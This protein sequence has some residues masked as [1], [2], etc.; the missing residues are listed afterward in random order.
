MDTLDVIDLGAVQ[1]LVTQGI[2]KELDPSRLEGFIH[3]GRFVLEVEV[4]LE[5]CAAP[6][7]NP[8]SKAL[9]LQ[10]LGFGNFLHLVCSERRNRNHGVAGKYK[11]SRG[12]LL[13]GV[14]PDLV[15]HVLCHVEGSA[16]LAS[17][18]FD[19][20]YVAFCREHLGDSEDRTLAED[21]RAL[22][23][24]APDHR[25]LAR[26]QLLAWLFTSAERGQAA[27]PI[28][29]EALRDDEVDRP[30]LLPVLRQRL[31]AVEILRCA[32]ELERPFHARLPAVNPGSVDLSLVMRAAPALAEHELRLVRALRLRGRVYGNEIWVGVPDPVLG[33]SAEHVSWQAAHE[34]TVAEVSRARGLT[35]REVE[36]A[37][38]VVLA[39]RA[40]GAGL[41]AEH[42]T[43]LS[44]FGT[45]APSTAKNTL[46]DAAQK[47]V[48]E[49]VR[50]K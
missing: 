48:D 19:S 36:H 45:N 8:E 40:R 23:L 47:L 42:G 15:F 44:H 26:L 4:V 25:E 10:T 20:R 9:A 30:R 32:V 46:P 5:T 31:E 1:V 13:A 21:A 24:V 39:E 33:P 18:V 16:H 28:E 17:S 50:S 6:T 38:V 35:E 41:F 12:G 49:L 22:A 14:W 34:A 27:A 43:W 2:N 29:L 3:L 37:A 11:Q 7:H